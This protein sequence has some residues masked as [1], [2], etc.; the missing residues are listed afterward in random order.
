MVGASFQFKLSFI[1]FIRQKPRSKNGSRIKIN[2]HWKIN[3]ETTQVT[4]P[5][6]IVTTSLLSLSS[7]TLG[8]RLKVKITNLQS[9][10]LK[11]WRAISSLQAYPWGWRGRGQRE[12]STKGSLQSSNKKLQIQA[13]SKTDLNTYSAIVDFTRCHT[14]LDANG[15]KS[16]LIPSCNRDFT[17]GFRK[18]GAPQLLLMPPQGIGQQLAYTS[19]LYVQ[20]SHYWKWLK[21]RLY[22]TQPWI[23][24]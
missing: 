13:N 5:N 24:L 4:D 7:N 9:L 1:S 14:M 2:S 18:S 21:M 3:E 23:S 20:S 15:K 17:P 6:C 22:P 11:N 8:Y 12:R 10:W 19:L 16:V